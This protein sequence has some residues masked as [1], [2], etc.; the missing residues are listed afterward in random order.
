MTTYYVDPASGGSDSGTMANPWT[1]IQSAMNTVAAGDIVYCTGTQTLASSKTLQTA[2]T[3]AAYVE[4][5]GTTPAWAD[6]GTKFIMDAN[7]AAAFCVDAA[8]IDY[9]FFKNFEFKNAT[10]DGVGG[11]STPDLYIYQNCDFNN[12]ARYGVFSQRGGRNLHA[13]NCSFNNNSSYGSFNGLGSYSKCQFIGNGDYGLRLSGGLAVSNSLFHNNTNGGIYLITNGPC[14]SGCTIDGETI[15]I[16]VANPPQGIV[17][18][19]ITNCTT[20]ITTTSAGASFIGNCFFYGNGTDYSTAGSVFV[21]SYTRVSGDNTSDGYTDRASDDFTLTDGG[22]GTF[23]EVPIGDYSET[24]NLSYQTQGITPNPSPGGAL[25]FVGISKF[26]ILSN[27]KFYIEWAAATGGTPS[28]YNIY[29]DTSTGAFSNLVKKVPG[30]VTSTV[31][32]LQSDNSTFVQGGTTYYCSVR[33]ED[34]TGA[35]D[36]NVLELSNIASGSET[37][38]RMTNT[39]VSP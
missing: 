30:T 21:D 2:G 4:W 35:E 8:D 34:S 23:V 19:R 1:D 32:S 25:T 37:I 31:V 10:S 3:A 27:N 26:E 22:E 14:I 33:A 15:G 18:C 5:I 13:A 16:N 7:S 17:D 39:V 38:Q 28:S 24:T 29:M 6:D 12:N 9:Q 36:T 11:V 20:G